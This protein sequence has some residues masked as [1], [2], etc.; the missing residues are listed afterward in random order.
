LP[1]GPHP[2]SRVAVDGNVHGHARAGRAHSH[3]PAPIG[4][5]GAAKSGRS[6]GGLPPG[7]RRLPRSPR[8]VAGAPAMAVNSVHCPGTGW[9]INGVGPFLGRSAITR[10]ITRGPARIGGS[11][12][13]SS[14]RSSPS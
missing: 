4:L 11:H 6:P 3:R 12:N 9:R 5:R 8:E 10:G 14:R 13:C 1:T 7:R 2:A